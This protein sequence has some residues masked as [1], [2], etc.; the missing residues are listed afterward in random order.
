M[1]GRTTA[2]DGGQGFFRW[3][4]G[5]QS[6]NVTADT[7]TG[8]WVPP[9]SDATGASGAWK[10][11]Y[12]GPVNVRWFG[13]TGDGATND[14]T[15]I[16]AA[17]DYV[18]ALTYGGTVIFPHGD[19]LCGDVILKHKVRLQGELKVSQPNASSGKLTR[20]VGVAGASW[21][22]D[23]PA[24]EIRSSS[25]I[26]LSFEGTGAGGGQGGVRFRFARGSGVA[27]CSFNNFDNQAIRMDAGG[28]CTFIDNMAQNCLLNRTQASKVGVLQITGSDNY[29]VR[30]EYTASSSLEGDISDANLR[31]CAVA[32]LGNS[33][34]NWIVDTV[35]EISDIG[36]Y[37][38]GSHHKVIGVRADLNYAHGF[39][40]ACTLSIFSACHG[41]RNGQAADATYHDFDIVSGSAALNMFS[42]CYGVSDIG[43]ANRVQHA[44]NDGV[45]SDG[46]K[47]FYVGCRGH[48]MRGSQFNVN[49][50]SGGAVT[51]MQ[52][53]AKT[54]TD[55]DT[56][57]SVDNYSMFRWLNPSVMTIT[58]FDDGVPGQTIYVVNQSNNNVSVQNGT[59]I[60]TSTGADKA[61]R[62]NRVYAFHNFLG[63]W[64][65][66]GGEQNQV[67]ADVGDT[68]K[69]LTVGLSEP[70]QVWDTALTADRSVSLSTTGAYNGAKFRIVRTANATGAFNLNVGTGPLKAL[71]VGEW[72]DVEYNGS[73]WMLTAFGS[74]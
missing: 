17:I 42:G 15:A 66:I 36:L 10:R 32:I 58:N 52:G 11:Q 34:N 54:F 28:T 45:A 49:A 22:I 1:L 37:I 71:A 30:G 39:Q 4:S 16:Q 31:I 19:Y 50:T 33:G 48:G 9:D 72:C 2:G 6:A 23:T 73:A 27:N 55:L 68:N 64:Y 8:V 63:K 44:F 13:A 67:G 56:T 5:D 51:V 14:T 65:E 26:G 59:N 74:L 41:F 18:A 38:E 29:I 46:S 47:N 25:I 60:F 43:D 57:P 20:L 69:T 21:I 3:V 61:L 24:T 53:P 70:T 40:V 35:A 12:S 7:Q 62:Q